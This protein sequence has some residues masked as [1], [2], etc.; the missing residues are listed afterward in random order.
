MTPDQLAQRD[1]RRIW[2]AAYIV[3]G[4]L[5]VFALLAILMFLFRHQ[6][7]PDPWKVI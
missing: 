7:L 1:R 3:G 6:I 2:I 4:A 5:A